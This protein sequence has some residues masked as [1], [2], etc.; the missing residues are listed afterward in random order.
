[1]SAPFFRSFF[2]R[3]GIPNIHTPSRRACSLLQTLFAPLFH[4]NRSILIYILSLG[5]KQTK[6]HSV[7]VHATSRL[8]MVKLNCVDLLWETRIRA[9]MLLVTGLLTPLVRFVEQLVSLDLLC[10][11]CFVQ[12]ARTE[13]DGFL[14]L[15][16]IRTQLA[17]CPLWDAVTFQS[18]ISTPGLVFMK[19]GKGFTA[20][21]RWSVESDSPFPFWQGVGRCRNVSSC[22]TG[23]PP[24]G[25]I[26]ELED[27][28]L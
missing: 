27:G 22:K 17:A 10:V 1:M 16:V 13:T 25:G 15:Q 26:R 14:R 7:R 9:S 3:T 20:P 19:E 8:C 23:P 18:L 28:E 12:H 5:K 4:H 2:R 11:L 21:D 6:L 24:Q